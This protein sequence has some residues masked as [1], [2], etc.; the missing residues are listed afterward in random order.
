MAAITYRLLAKTFNE[1]YDA[2]YWGKIRALY[3]GGPGVR[4][5]LGDKALRA[6]LFPKHLGEEEYVYIERVKR[7]YLIPYMTF[8]IDQLVSSL[9]TDP[10]RMSD[11]TDDGPEGSPKDIAADKE[12]IS[13]SGKVDGDPFYDGLMKNCARPDAPRMS[14]NELMKHQL[15]DALLCRRSWAL[16]DLPRVL[17]GEQPQSR[18]EEEA[19]G[20]NEPYVCHVAPEAVVDWELNDGGELLWAN[21]C[22]VSRR[23][24][25]IDQG[26][27]LVAE[28]YTV[29]TVDTWTRYT[30]EYDCE[31]YPH[32]PDDETPPTRIETGAHSFGK[33]PLVQFELPEGLWAGGKLEG[34]QTQ[35]FNQESALAWSMYRSL[36]Q[37]IVVQLSEPDPLN[38]ASED[39]NRATNQ[40][41]GPGRIMQLAKDDKAQFLGPD[42]GPFDTAMKKQDQIRDEMF[43]IMHQLAAASDNSA[44]S[45]GRSANS[46]QA[47]QQ[48]MLIV[49]R[50]LG[51]RVRCHAEDIFEMVSAGRGEPDRTFSAQGADQFDAVSMDSLVTEAALLETIPIPSPTF[52]ALYKFELVRGALP[53]ATEEQLEVIMS[54]LEQGITAEEELK[55]A[56]TD[57]Q[58]SRVQDGQLPGEPPPPEP[59]AQDTPPA[60]GPPA[61][62]AKKSK[63]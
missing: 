12:E 52:Q 31:E 8:L 47:D 35:H 30:W 14:L 57:V 36:F 44:A 5:A 3:E 21:V 58:M 37:F 26:R 62:A 50:E 28:S 55:K 51:R 17:D 22:N 15:L 23:R 7:A 60:K 1:N 4:R 19:R 38:P 43:R 61:K 59:G 45:S 11:D 29:Y 53:G 16:V 63:K 34:L 33:V 54:E 24:P 25:S 56:S 18:A 41:I 20:L 32:G 48:T 49:L 10:I 40:V 27:T 46:K 39:T 13:I 6:Q 9:A 42:A 2:A